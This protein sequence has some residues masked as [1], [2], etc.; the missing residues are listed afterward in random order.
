MSAALAHEAPG[1]GLPFAD[2]EG[3]V[4]AVDV[5]VSRHDLAAMDQVIAAVHDLV[6]SPVYRERVLS[7]APELA[8]APM[9]P[10]FGLFS[11]FDFHLTP[12]GPR[13]I[14]INTNAGGAFYGALMDDS[15]YRQGVPGA[16]PLG[17]WSELFVRQ[18]LGP[19]VLDDLLVDGGLYSQLVA[20]VSRRV[21]LGLRQDFL[22]LPSSALQARVQ[23]TSFSATF[24]F[25]EFARLRAH[26]ER[27]TTATEG[28]GFFSGPPVWGAYL[29]L[30][31]SYGAHGAHPF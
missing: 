6:M 3:R 26:V 11:G 25:S 22:G 7:G 10:D 9:Q 12:E 18:V 4:A 17:Y 2:I 16:H 15:R 21:F 31:V 1:E 30:E 23:R 27:E 8:R 14:E 5:P 28:L 19:E 29:Q 13:L 20:Q 24:A